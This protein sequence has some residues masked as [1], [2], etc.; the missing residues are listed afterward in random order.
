MSFINDSENL[1]LICKDKIY[2]AFP[3]L[4]GRIAFGV[5][6][7]GSECYGFEDALSRD[8]DYC[9]GFCLFI[10]DE[11]DIRFGPRLSRLYRELTPSCKVNKS[12]LGTKKLGVIRS[13]DFY[14]RYLGTPSAPET[15]EQWLYLPSHAL[16]EATNGKIFEDTLGEF[17]KVRNTL[18]YGMPEDVRKK[19]IAAR[20]VSMAQSGQYNYKRCLKHGEKGSAALAVNEFASSCAD[21]VFL[22]NRAHAPYYKWVFKKM[23]SLEILSEEREK[24]I[25]LLSSPVEGKEELIEDIS[26]DIISELIL[27]GLTTSASDYLEDHAFSVMDKIENMQIKSLHVMEG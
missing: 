22:L 19:K 2:D 5:A 26:G 20:C 21:L 23:G 10:T 12:A 9:D 13:S 11:D 24:L 17:S 8:H 18:L 6:G 3:Q 25:N 7:P 16:A 15:L 1:F 4:K 27:Q 14:M